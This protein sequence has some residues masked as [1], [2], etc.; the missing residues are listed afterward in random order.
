MTFVTVPFVMRTCLGS[1]SWLLARPL[2]TLL[3]FV[4]E[5]N[6]ND[7]RH[8][9]FGP[10]LLYGLCRNISLNYIFCLTITDR[11]SHFLTHTKLFSDK[12]WWAKYYKLEITLRSSLGA[13]EECKQ[14]SWKDF[15]QSN[16]FSCHIINYCKKTHKI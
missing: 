6:H 7:K 12:Q 9:V 16:H 10:L 11:N 4:R 5:K 15:L 3:L 2:N 8:S 1:C 14:S 13:T